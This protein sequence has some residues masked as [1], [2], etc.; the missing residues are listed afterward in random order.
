MIYLDHNATTPLRNEGFEAMVLAYSVKQAPPKELVSFDFGLETTPAEAAIRP[1]W[2]EPVDPPRVD[3]TD[4]AEGGSM[5]AF[6]VQLAKLATVDFARLKDQIA[7][8]FAQLGNGFILR[9]LVEATPST[10]CPFLSTRFE[11]DRW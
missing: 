6:S 7:E 5:D 9:E 1:M 10:I 11:S 3:V 8:G 4:A 2:R